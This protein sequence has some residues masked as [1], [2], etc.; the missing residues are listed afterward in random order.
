MK[1]ALIAR[2]AECDTPENHLRGLFF[3]ELEVY[4]MKNSLAAIV[5]LS[6]LLTACGNGAVQDTS[7]INDQE[8]KETI[9]QLTTQ[10]TVDSLEIE[11]VATTAQITTETTEEVTTVVTTEEPTESTTEE[12][13]TSSVNVAELP[14]IYNY[15]EYDAIYLQDYL[16]DCG[17]TNVYFEEDIGGPVGLTAEFPNW[18][19]VIWFY[20]SNVQKFSVYS[21]DGSEEYLLECNY[22]DGVLIVSG[23]EYRVAAEILYVLPQLV[24]DILEKEPAGEFVFNDDN[25]A[26]VTQRTD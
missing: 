2:K 17:A 24:Q 4:I 23:Y 20:L 14:D 12:V 5:T 1:Y 6:V 15:L 10:T 16:T 22:S 11:P 8:T 21:A 9:T 13:A 25:L 19:L 26:N 3:S 18:K 7:G